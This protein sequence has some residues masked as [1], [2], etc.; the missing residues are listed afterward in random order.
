MKI[1]QFV[2]LNSQQKKDAV[3]K[4]AAIS[5]KLDF[6]VFGVRGE[7]L[8]EESLA[9]GASP[10]A[11]FIFDEIDESQVDVIYRENI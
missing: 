5:E 2:Q 3:A 9:K 1:L 7:K 8:I 10:D 11:E 4:I 6:S